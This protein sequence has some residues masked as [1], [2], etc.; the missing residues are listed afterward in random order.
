M[1][2][3]F[4]KNRELSHISYIIG[5][6]KSKKVA[7]VDP[8]RDISPYVEYIQEHGLQLSYVLN[9]H[10]HAD[11]VSGHRQVAQQLDAINVYAH[12]VPATFPF[13]SVR[14][15][16]VLHIGDTV[17]VRVMETPGHTPFCLSFLIEEDGLEKVLFSG[18]FLFSGGIGRPD[19]LGEETKNTLLE[20][21]YQSCLRLGGLPEHMI[22]CPS[23]SGGTMCGKDL[24][25]SFLSTIGIE[26]RLNK[27]FS[28]ALENKEDFVAYL[29]SQD[30]DTPA[31]FKK[32]G[33][34]NL[35]GAGKILSAGDIPVLRPDEAVKQGIKIVD[36]RDIHAFLGRHI[37][38]S[39][40]IAYNANVALIAGSVLIQEESYILLLPETESPKDFLQSILKKLGS[41]GI[42]KIVGV[43]FD[44]IYRL[45]QSSTLLSSVRSVHEDEVRASGRFKVIELGNEKLDGTDSEKVEL[46]H[47]RE[48]DFKPDVDYT[49]I[50]SNSFKSMAAVSLLLDRSNIYFLLR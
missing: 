6:E 5:C 45:R 36:M 38:G 2:L 34:I 8:A 41:V 4:F 23:H 30:I 12:N 33:A 25:D 40:N 15:N 49:F 18:D 35:Q 17:K 50:C 20:D 32:M 37:Q 16:D 47:I 31:H 28:L 42:D 22:I 26:K 1:I 44:G 43:V 21:A 9:T 48:Y 39:V 29:A 46:S 10:P 11:F 27:A 24:K 13:H 3:D 19:L 7:L 14:D